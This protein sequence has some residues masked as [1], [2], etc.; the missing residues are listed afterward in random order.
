MREHSWLQH[1]QHFEILRLRNREDDTEQ[2]W[3]PLCSKKLEDFFPFD[4]E[5][6]AGTASDHFCWTYLQRSLCINPYVMR[7]PRVNGKLNFAKT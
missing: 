5:S 1:F 2:I 6:V 3:G 7:R 4:G